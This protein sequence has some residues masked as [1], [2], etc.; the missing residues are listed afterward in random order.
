MPNDTE[1]LLS[2]MQREMYKCAVSP[3]NKDQR[4]R[5]Y[6]LGTDLAAAIGQSAVNQ[7]LLKEATFI[8]HYKMIMI[9]RK[10]KSLRH[11]FVTA[12]TITKTSFPHTETSP[13]ARRLAA[14]LIQE[15]TCFLNHRFVITA[16][17]TGLPNA[18]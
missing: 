15:Y 2:T 16:L 10:T 14:A 1:T 13:L 4:R 9:A 7:L 8:R 5:L 12:R 18:R 11:R 6:L 3:G 17:C